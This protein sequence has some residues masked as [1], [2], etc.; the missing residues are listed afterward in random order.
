MRTESELAVK[1]AAANRPISA[2]PLMLRQAQDE[3]TSKTLHP[4]LVEG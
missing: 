4:E 3:G 1:E 2:L